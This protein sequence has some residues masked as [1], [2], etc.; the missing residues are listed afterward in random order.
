VVIAK[1]PFGSTGHE[2]TRTI[3]GAAAL[4][5]VTQEEADR[6]LDLLAER[7]VN[8]IDTAASYGDSELRLA[9]WLAHNRDSVFLATKT[10]ERNRKEAREE[11]RRSLDRL[12][13][14]HVD[15]IQLHN[16][17]DVIEWEFALREG[18]ALEAAVEARDEGLVRFIGVTG[19][20]LTV[21]KMHRR[22]LE[23]FAFDSVLLPYSYVQMQDERYASEWEA[24]AATCAERGIAM[25]TIK[26]I[27]LAPWDGREQTAG[28]WYEPLTEQEDIDVAVHWV[29]GRPEVF[30][31]T[32]GDVT[33]L[34]KVLDAASRFESRPSDEVMDDLVERRTLVP[35]FS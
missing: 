30:L 29:L 23:R 33:L 24:L 17:V 4:G 1:A 35:L 19:H 27:S 6:A 7:G 3:F 26:A 21:P 9:P 10:G 31:N 16:L 14:D 5:S 12:G 28:T 13:V 2:S 34:P 15:L 11:I 20:G 8:H 18:G 32:A 22:S 25:Q